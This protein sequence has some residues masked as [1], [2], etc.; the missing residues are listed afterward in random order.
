M[1]YAFTAMTLLGISH[2][3]FFWVMTEPKYSRSKTALIY[4]GFVVLFVCLTTLIYAIFGNSIG[5]FSITFT[6][7][8]VV[9]FLIFLFTSADPICKKVF[10][11][12]SYANAFC[13]FVCI[14]LMLCRV[15]FKGA[16]DIFVYYA[17][18]IVRT[19]LFLPM[20][21]VYVRFLRPSVRAVSG[22]RRKT[23]YSISTVSFLFL[24][25]FALFLM[26]FYDK[27]ERIG[28]YAPFFAVSV[29]I[30]A[31]IL[32]VI[33]G[34]IKSMIDESNTELINQNIAY[35][36]GQLKTAKENELSAKTVRHD[37]RHHNQNIETM[38]EKGEVDEALCYL[39]QY[40]D[41][42]DEIKPNDFCPNITVNAILTSF[43]TNAQKN[44][45]SISIEA[46]TAEH[47]AISDMDFVA[48]LSNL[49]ENAVNGC[50]EC[51]SDG[52]ITVNIRTVANKI[53]IVCSNP[54]RK[55]IQIENN[56][57]KKRGIGISSI[58][59]AIRKYDGDIKYSYENNILTVCIILNF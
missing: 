29:L 45:L 37:F 1:M 51:Q 4:S 14:S 17:R 32:W 34:T 13:I 48:V 20:A 28:D 31:S 35:L 59:S 18:N 49:L 19:V 40:N 22:Q 33:F 6:S 8:I 9:A 47:T 39:K 5:Y 57:L 38:L 36:Q 44:G 11:F 27:Y 21:Y 42:L 56:M 16:P 25:I 10:L 54:C 26:I 15:L 50:V 23:W 24:V 2:F 55:D 41:S 7:T 30:Y 43:Y 12:I 53:V 3:L 52:K 46:D 58:L